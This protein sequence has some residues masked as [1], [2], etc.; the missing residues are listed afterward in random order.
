[1]AKFLTQS[2]FLLLVV[3]QGALYAELLQD[4]T[5]PPAVMYASSEKSTLSHKSGSPLL[6]SV[7]LGTDT[8]Y[9]MISGETVMLGDRFGHYILVGLKADEARLMAEDGTHLVLS[10]DFQVEKK[11]LLINEKQHEARYK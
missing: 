8:K 3:H 6:Q 1:M 4:P 10:M 2:I 11:P 9:A 7:T 5:M